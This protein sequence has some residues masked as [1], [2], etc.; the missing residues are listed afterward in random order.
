MSSETASSLS[1]TLQITHRSEAHSLTLPLST[2]LESLQAQIYTLTSVPVH[3][4]KLIW[5]NQPKAPLDSTVAIGELRLKNGSKIMVVGNPEAD[6]GVM[7]NVE[8]EEQRRAEIMK[9]R[10]ARG[11]TK[12]KIDILFIEDCS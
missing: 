3:L 8:G 9:Q 12:V 4:Q 5:K 6:L 2:S 7:R 1:V 11:P 10:E